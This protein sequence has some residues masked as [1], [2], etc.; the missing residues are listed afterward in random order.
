MT[1]I[2]RLY[3]RLEAVIHLFRSDAYILIATSRKTPVTSIIT[4]CPDNLAIAERLNSIAQEIVNSE[5]AAD[6]LLNELGIK[7]QSE[8]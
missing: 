1:A 7:T 5:K 4:N 3:A 2:V 6:S 8:D